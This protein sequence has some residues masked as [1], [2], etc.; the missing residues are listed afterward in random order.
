MRIFAALP[1]PAE[2][3]VAIREAFSSAR[4]LA[5]RARWVDAEG[6]HLTLH[7]FGEIPEDA[8]PGFGPLFDDP[9][10]RRPAIASQLG[11][12]GFFPPS[13]NPRVLWI[14]LEKGVDEMREFY[15]VFTSKLH[16]LRQPGGPLSGWSPDVRGFMPHVTVARAGSTPLGTHWADVVKVPQ[17]GFLI[18]ECVLFQSV[19]GTGRARYVPLKTVAFHRGAA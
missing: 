15:A 1:L 9:G 16:P 8:V 13:G 10:L 7:F 4:T 3:T 12:V 18:T 19:L 6:M 14:G 11:P 2:T 5:P 17:Q